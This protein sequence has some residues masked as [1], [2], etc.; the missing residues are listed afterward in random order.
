MYYFARSL[1][2]GTALCWHCHNINTHKV[3]P[4]LHGLVCGEHL[5]QCRGCLL[6]LVLVGLEWVVHSYEGLR[7]CILASC[8]RPATAAPCMHTQIIWSLSLS[9]VRFDGSC[10]MEDVMDTFPPLTSCTVPPQ[11]KDLSVNTSSQDKTENSIWAVCQEIKQ[12]LPIPSNYQSAGVQLWAPTSWCWST[13][14]PSSLPGRRSL[15][16]VSVAHSTLSH[17]S[18]LQECQQRAED[19]HHGHSIATYRLIRCLF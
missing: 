12:S 1:V 4:P 17:A 7:V 10:W 6:G 5:K 14:W 16:I 19:L 11:P 2:E 8:R 18:L 9:P 13:A 3:I 15:Q